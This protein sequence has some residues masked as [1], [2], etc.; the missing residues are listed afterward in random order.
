MR[1]K[2][3]AV[4]VLSVAMVAFAAVAF[5]ARQTRP[6]STQLALIRL[7]GRFSYAA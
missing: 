7:G 5:E 3:A 2:S 1:L 6:S 4:T